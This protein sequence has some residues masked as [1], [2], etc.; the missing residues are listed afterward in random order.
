MPY[1]RPRATGAG[2][3]K[4]K[5]MIEVMNDLPENVLGVRASGEVTSDD[6]TTT[7]VPALEDKLTRFKKARLLYVLSLIHI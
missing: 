3:R 4:G 6:Y 7:L 2:K 5:L 1:F